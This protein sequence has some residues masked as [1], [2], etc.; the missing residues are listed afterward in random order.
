MGLL[1]AWQGTSVVLKTLPQAL[2]RAEEIGLD[3]RVLFFTLVISLLSGIIFGLA[4]A[5]KLWRTDVQKALKEG[6]RGSSEARQRVQNVFVMLEMAMALV[7]L[8]GAG[9]MVRSLA[10]LWSV[11]PGF[12]THNVLTFN[13]AFP[14]SMGSD[15]QV[16]RRTLRELNDQLSALPNDIGAVLSDGARLYESHGPSFTARSLHRRTGH[17]AHIWRCSD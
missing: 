5:L 15:P 14:S 17:G 10:R 3:S 2:P 7:L 6:G 1:L 13:V 16:I 4:P 12:N 8:V 9:L 11:D